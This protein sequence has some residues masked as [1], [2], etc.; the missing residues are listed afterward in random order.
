MSEK[1]SIIEMQ[2]NFYRDRPTMCERNSDTAFLL[3]RLYEEVEELK[4]AP[5]NH[6]GLEKH[7]EQEAVD[8]V[9]FAL[10]FLDALM[11]D[12]E[13]AIREKVARNVIKFQPKLFLDSVDYPLGISVSNAEWKRERGDQ[14][15][16]EDV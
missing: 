13:E 5:T 14:I 1:L 7:Q 8:V 10:A 11:G 6:L 2:R 9:L 12:A 3:A 16:Y 4:N 15:F